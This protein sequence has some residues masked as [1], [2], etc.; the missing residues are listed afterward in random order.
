MTLPD[1]R[2]VTP[3]YNSEVKELFNKMRDETR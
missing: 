1:M 2:G 3:P